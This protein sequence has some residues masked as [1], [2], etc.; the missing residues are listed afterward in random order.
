MRGDVMSSIIHSFKSFIACRTSVSARVNLLLIQ[1]FAC[2]RHCCRLRVSQGLSRLCVSLID[3]FWRLFSSTSAIFTAC[4]AHW[5]PSLPIVVRRSWIW[6]LRS[7]S[8]RD[9]IKRSARKCHANNVSY[10]ID[11][12]KW[13]TLVLRLNNRQYTAWD[14]DRKW[15]K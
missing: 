6:K 14:Q 12:T 8:T 1:N 7:H 11:Y 13:I 15:I 5:L 10:T 4:F 9:S 3:V 2:W